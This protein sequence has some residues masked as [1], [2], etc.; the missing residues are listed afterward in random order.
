MYGSKGNKSVNFPDPLAPSEIKKG[1]AYGLQY[2]KSI[3]AQWG[4]AEQDNS[5]MRNRRTVFDRNRKY[6]NGTQ[7]TSIYRQLLTSLDPSNGDGSFL[8]IDFTPVPILPKFVRIVVNKILSSDPYPNLEAIDP[9]S[10]SEKD[11]ERRKL[12]ATIRNREKLIEAQKKTGVQIADTDKI[13]ETLE[14]A[15][16]F[17]GNNIKSSSEIAA[18]V[19]A[20]MTLRWNDFTDSTYRRCVNDLAT[21]GMAVTKRSNDPS[22]GIKVEY[23]DPAEFVHSFT[24]DPNFKDLVYAGHVKRIPIQELKRIAGDQFT[25]EEYKKIAQKAAKKYGYDTSGLNKSRYDDYLKRYKFGYDEYMIEVMD[26]EFLSVDPMYFEEKESRYGNV[27]FYQKGE[28]YKAPTNSVFN[29]SVSKLENATVYGGCYILGCD[30]IFNYGLKTNIPKNMHDLSKANMSYSVVATNMEEMIPKSMVNSCIGFADQLQ[31]TH[32][33]I[34][35]AIAKAK[36]DGIIIDIEGLENVQ[37]GKGGELQPLEL[38]DIYEQTGVFY[39]RSKNP[40]G[41]FQNPP[42]REINNSVRNINE[43]IALYNHYL[44]MIRDATGI[45]EAM[46]GTTPKGEQLVGVRQQAIAA[47]NN[48]IYDITNSSMLL[49]KK[50]CSDIVKCLQ[51]I[52]KNSILFR[53][54]E[55]AIGKENMGMLNTFSKLSMYN[56][57]VTVVKEMEEVEKQY[58]EQNIQVSLAQK[59]LDIED[60]I[61]IRQL[62]DINQAERLLV[63]R[64]KKRMAAN[65][66]IAQ[67]NV[68]MQAQAQ[69]QSAQAA[70]QA[71]M[72]EM[73]M[74]AQIDSQ[75]E[76][77]KAQL[78]AQMETLKHEHRKEI[79]MIKAQATLGFRTEQEE[80]REKLEVLKEDRKDERVKKQAVE[81][82]KL[83][84]QRQGERGELAEQPESGQEESPQD[85]ISQIIQNADS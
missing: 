17:I 2:A 63:V 35:Q 37:L 51:I 12:E 13:P 67:Q 38:H 65:Q 77:M 50:V 30:M 40:E 60:A 34:Q 41:G 74:K 20:N 45:N 31:L 42:I 29:R 4:S 70:S 23:V 82:S 36:P 18:Q 22:E 62:K 55:T 25:E 46:D 1:K 54:Y 66:Q 14:E 6:A 56:F 32:L 27:G 52:P 44:R 39:Y 75:M 61:A 80:F 49:F 71:K 3:A 48:A 79:E 19:A 7:D 10:S 57:G 11:R 15:E 43:F 47:G 73:Q 68:Q 24:T 84:A 72:Q 64:R 21:L 59:E 9:L 78:D 58:L 26:F 16:I 8:N 5:L 85:I 28:N 81:Q 69:A 53:A 83:V 33:K 76:Q